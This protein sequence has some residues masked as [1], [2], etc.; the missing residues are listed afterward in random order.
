MSMLYVC[1]HAACPC[2]R[3]TW[4]RQV[5]EHTGTVMVMDMYTGTDMNRNREQTNGREYFKR[6]EVN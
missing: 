2:L 3:R 5:K 4:T 1:I 6:I